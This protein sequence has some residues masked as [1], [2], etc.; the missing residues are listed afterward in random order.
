MHHQRRRRKRQ[1]RDWAEREGTWRGRRTWVVT[2]IRE[3]NPNPTYFKFTQIHP[4]TSSLSWDRGRWFKF[5][6]LLVSFSICY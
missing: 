1:S 2:T 5:L 6:E 4:R 3:R